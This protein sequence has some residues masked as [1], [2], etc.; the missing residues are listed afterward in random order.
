MRDSLYFGVIKQYSTEESK[1]LSKIEREILLPHHRAHRVIRRFPSGTVYLILSFV[2]KTTRQLGTKRVKRTLM[3]LFKPGKPGLKR[4]NRAIS[5]FGY[6]SIELLQKA[7]HVATSASAAH[8]VSSQ[9][10]LMLHQA[11]STEGPSV[12]VAE[13]A[14]DCLSCEPEA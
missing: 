11:C 7:F 8:D 10:C 13:G 9:E 2:H 14:E 1:I 12:C 5:W 4:L 6:C 3:S